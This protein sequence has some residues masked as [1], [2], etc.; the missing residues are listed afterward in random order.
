MPMHI[1]IAATQKIDDELLC[2]CRIAVIKLIAPAAA[3]CCSLVKQIALTN[4]S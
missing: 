2:Y 1:I 3:V 4:H